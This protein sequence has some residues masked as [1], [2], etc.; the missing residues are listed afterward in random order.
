VRG[1]IVPRIPTSILLFLL[2]AGVNAAVFHVR[3]GAAGNKSGADW[4]NAF[5]SLPPTL[6]RG[7]TYYIADGTYGG[8]TFDD[9]EQGGT[10][11]TLKKA[12]PADHGSPAGWQ[13]S[14]GDDAAVFTGTL[15]FK[16]GYYTIDG[17]VG[18]SR[19]AQAYG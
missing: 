10:P 6:V 18:T 7:S 14:M 11:V 1:K 2:C 16:A 12:I 17:Q 15:M 5:P 8:Y 3:E 19:T 13:D 4:T 9:P